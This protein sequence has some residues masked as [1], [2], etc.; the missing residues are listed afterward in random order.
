MYSILTLI[1]F[2]AGSREIFRRHKVKENSFWRKIIPFKETEKNPLTYAK[3]IPVLL[4]A[5]ILICVIILYIVYWSNSNLLES[6]FETKAYYIISVMVILPNAIYS[7][8][9][10]I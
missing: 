6:F 7:G 5:L 2:R 1:D 9:L 4:Q 3:L 10:M 8:I